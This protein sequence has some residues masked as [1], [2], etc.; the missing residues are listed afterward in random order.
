MWGKLSSPSLRPVELVHA[1]K[2]E[3]LEPT[4][5]HSPLVTG[6]GMMIQCSDPNTKQPPRATGWS[7]DL[8]RLLTLCSRYGGEHNLN[9]SHHWRT[10]EPMIC[11]SDH[12]YT[13]RTAWF[14]LYLFFFSERRRSV[15]SSWTILHV[16]WKD[17]C[18]TDVL[19]HLRWL[20]SIDSSP[21]LIL[22][23]TTLLKHYLI[24]NELFFQIIH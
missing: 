1:G 20:S 4:Q 3:P 12:F 18:Q 23:N 15:R 19:A 2:D 22:H 21:L 14:S 10:F 11:R 13:G 7:L 17:H 5:H 6:W 8:G 9:C 16:G 24:L